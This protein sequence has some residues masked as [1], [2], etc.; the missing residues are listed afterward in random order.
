MAEPH[1]TEPGREEI[2]RAPR[3]RAT[4]VASERLTPPDSPEEVR[5][6]ILEVDAALPPHHPGQSV[7]VFVPG[8]HLHGDR[9][10]VRLYTVADLP[11]APGGTDRRRLRL[12]VRRCSW[13]DPH[14][15][16]RH[17]GVASNWLCDLPDG[18]ELEIAGPLGAPFPVPDD[19]DADLVL[20]GLGTGIAPFRALLR[21]LHARQPDR[22]GRVRLFYG[23]RS[24]LELLYLNDWRDDVAQY[25][26]EDTW[27]AIEA[28]SPRP[29]WDE[30]ADLEGAL[31]AHEAEL[32]ELLRAPDTQV[33]LA[34]LAR[35]RDAFDAACARILG[36]DARWAR[37]RAELVA[38]GRWHEVV[39]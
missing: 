11:D 16:E 37:R 28:L 21:Q 8:P 30:P 15:G 6:L 38:G 36:S 24:G 1:T 10:L 17:P 20:V 33:Y 26:D 13:L 35:V 29:E 39:Y 34:G 31:A 3:H 12:C 2:D 9:E 23:A 22:R 18:T 14:T 5:E 32:G 4:L 25:L 27:R 19:P 7:A